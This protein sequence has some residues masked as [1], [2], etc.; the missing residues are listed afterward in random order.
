MYLCFFHIFG[1]LNNYNA[2]LSKQIIVKETLL[3]LKTHAKNG[4][5]L[6]KKRMRLLIELK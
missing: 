2:T 4:N 3:T 5:D 1:L 6:I